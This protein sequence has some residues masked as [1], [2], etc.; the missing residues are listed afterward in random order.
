MVADA[1]FGI[2]SPSLLQLWVWKAFK[3]KRGGV[4]REGKLVGWYLG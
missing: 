2:F 4:E 1:M 3:L